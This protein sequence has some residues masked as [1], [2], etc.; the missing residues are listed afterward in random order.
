MSYEPISDLSSDGLTTKGV[1]NI[2]FGN[3][4]LDDLISD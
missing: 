3:F 4:G 2:Y 1:V